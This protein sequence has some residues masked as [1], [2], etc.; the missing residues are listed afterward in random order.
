ML[1]A[2]AAAAEASPSL[3]QALG[4]D[5]RL[6]IEQTVAFLILVGVLAKFVCPTLVRAIDARRE[7]I[8]K[9]INEAKQAEQSLRDAEAKVEQMLAEARKEAD[10][11][12][13]RSHQAASETVA[14]AEKKGKVRAERIVAE[15][16]EQLERDVRHARESFK[17]DAVKLVAMATE[18]ITGEKFDAQKDAHMIERALGHEKEKS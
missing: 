7:E 3:F 10:E 14:E 1:L 6:L 12:I 13:A 9:G 11:I 16:H 8:E 5:T 2:F 18:K 17:S 15:A 4:L